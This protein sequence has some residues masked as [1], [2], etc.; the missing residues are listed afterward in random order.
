[1][2]QHLWQVL[3]IKVAA[4]AF[5]LNEC[6]KIQWIYLNRINQNIKQNRIEF[7]WVFKPAKVRAHTDKS[8]Q[9]FIIKWWRK[10][11]I[12]KSNRNGVLNKSEVICGSCMTKWF[13]MKDQ[14]VWRNITFEWNTRL[15]V[16]ENHQ[17]RAAG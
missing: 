16:K 8:R 17:R 10:A 4:R 2:I 12:Y 9:S 5:F 1:M 15:I 14:Q 3:G 11:F 7:T 6:L 13:I